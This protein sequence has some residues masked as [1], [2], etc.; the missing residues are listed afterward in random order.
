MGHKKTALHMKNTNQSKV[1]KEMKWTY[2]W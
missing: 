1:N 2:K